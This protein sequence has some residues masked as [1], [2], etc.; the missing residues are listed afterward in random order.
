MQVGGLG[1][2]P[3]RADMGSSI[4]QMFRS[5]RTTSTAVRY[6]GALALILG[7]V[8]VRAAL[9]PELGSRFPNAASFVACVVAARFLGLGPALFVIAA[10]VADAFLFGHHPEAGREL[11]F[12]VMCA[13]AV[14]IV[15][16]LRRATVK[17]E[18][19]AKLAADRLEELERAW[20]QRQEEEARSAQLRAIV[21]NSDDAIFSEDMEGIIRS[22]NMGAEHIFG[23][24][25]EEAIG[26][27]VSRLL[28]ANR[29]HEVHDIV[30]RVRRGGRVKH[31]VTQRIR[32]D[33]QTIHVSLTVSPIQDGQGRVTGA[34]H[35]A[36]DITEQTEL[37]EQFRQTQKLESLGVLA[38]G[39]AHDFNNL[40]TGIMGNASLA[41][42]EPRDPERT[43]RIDEILN[44][45]ERAALLIRQMLAYAGKG[46]F[47]VEP[48]EISS[49]IRELLP[50]LRT[51]MSRL[52]DLQLQLEPGL[53]P[54]AADRLQIQQVIMNVAINAAEAMEDR[55]GTVTISTRLKD[56]GDEREVVL[57]VRDSGIGMDEATQARMFDPFFTTKFTGRGLGLSAVM[58]IIRGHQGTISV[59]SVPGRGTTFTVVFPAMEATGEAAAP[60]PE[61][62]YRGYGKIL[63]VDDEELVRKMARFTLER[64]GYSVEVAADGPDGCACFAAR[65]DEFAAVLLDLSMPG[66]SGEEVLR[67]IRQVR[68]DVPV[69]L[70]SGFTESDAVQR[71]ENLGLAGFLQK[72]Y[73]ATA[74]AK[75]MKQAVRRPT[76]HT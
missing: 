42:E 56:A 76:P 55:P 17:A 33:G 58:G 10:A 15:E 6:S 48:L 44:A 73:T 46:Q 14:W 16:I 63:V 18:Q 43:Q 11:L 36:R 35:I 26:M 50:L 12:L 22:W 64:Y 68:R 24:T 13:V 2:N 72:P 8:L 27:P 20:A 70:S 4:D 25:A 9:S 5:G 49:Q 54:I 52:I 39:L 23:Y 53:P 51:S 28:P 61:S 67:R 74:L 60:G 7:A 59:D 71:F 47:V 66:M 69:V 3:Y 34:S 75:K 62:G 41:A 19:Q 29:E 21:E 30:E 45:S 57:E 40:L 32:K 38:G 37:E 65:P 1:T 31:F